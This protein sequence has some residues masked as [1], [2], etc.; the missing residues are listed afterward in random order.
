MKKVLTTLLATFLEIINLSSPSYANL[1]NKVAEP[2]TQKVQEIDKT[3]FKASYFD[4]S[5][6]DSINIPKEKIDLPIN[7]ARMLDR[8]KEVK[9]SNPQRFQREVL[10]TAEEIGYNQKKI[11]S[12]KPYE[13]VKLSCDIVKR[14]MDWAYVDDEEFQQK[15][16]KSL[17]IDTYFHMGKGECQRF[18]NATIATYS[19]LKKIN[20][21]PKTKNV[22]LT[23]Q[24]GGNLLP[25]EWVSIIIPSTNGIYC[26]HIDT[27]HYEDGGPL[28]AD[29]RH[30]NKDSFEHRFQYRLGNY[31]GSNKL[32]NA[33]LEKER[34]PEKRARLLAEKAKNFW[35][36]DDY[37]KSAKAYERASKLT[38][39]EEWKNL[40][41]NR[42]KEYFSKT[43]N[44]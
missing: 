30:V 2:Q 14:K 43:K 15:Y 25:H 35:N 33:L 27:S 1:E 16:G 41:S 21:N 3:N 22:Q 19:L 10:N 34:E 5:K 38:K 39:Y 12:L 13:L 40:W 37:L 29:S 8:K 36:L 4:F 31:E 6:M 26:S 7:V 9:I 44:N 23:R 17:S 11:S 42:A 32:I 20:S 28:E 24:I 18:A